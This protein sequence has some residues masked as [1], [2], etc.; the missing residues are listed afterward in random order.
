MD[1]TFLCKVFNA[2]S[3]EKW[4]AING[5]LS[6]YAKE[7]EKI[8]AEK[9]RLDTTAYETNI[10]YPTDS[11]LLWDSF[12]TLARLMKDA[13]DEMSRIGMRH[14]FHTKKVRNL[15]LYISR[16]SCKKDKKVQQKIQSI[17]RKLIERVKTNS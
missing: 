8:T 16:N 13:G 6:G 5:A 12:R 11:S 17:Y 7:K 10:H 1:Y 3:E 9:L 2:L 4:K 15:F 14:R